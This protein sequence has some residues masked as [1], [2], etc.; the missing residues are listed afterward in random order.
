MT[1]ATVVMAITKI[2]ECI[3][4]KHERVQSRVHGWMQW[5]DVLITTKPLR[6]V[7]YIVSSSFSLV[8]VRKLKWP[9]SNCIVS[10]SLSA[11]IHRVNFFGFSVEERGNEVNCAHEELQT[12]YCTC[13]IIRLGWVGK[14][15][16]ET[17]N[18]ESGDVSNCCDSN[19]SS[20]PGISFARREIK[21]GFELR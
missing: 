12:L 8:S 11:P 10:K 17:T 4:M 3:G 16:S 14:R 5:H 19:A 18:F 15:W 6:E 7:F 2:A 9:E 21:K 20:V 1:K 13:V